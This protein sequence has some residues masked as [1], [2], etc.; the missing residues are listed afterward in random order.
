MSKESREVEQIDGDA[1]A[2]C[3]EVSPTRQSPI[4]INLDESAV[5]ADNSNL[6]SSS[7][8]EDKSSS[9]EQI[10]QII[11]DTE[12]NLRSKFILAVKN[13]RVSFCFNFNR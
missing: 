3:D 8:L 6:S 10:V 7:T 9:S 4:I 1:H 11:D 13:I 12:E 2:S 5:E